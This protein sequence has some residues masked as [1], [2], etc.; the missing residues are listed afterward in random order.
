ML[1]RYPFRCDSVP[2]F[3]AQDT[4]DAFLSEYQREGRILPCQ[5]LAVV[6]SSVSTFSPWCAKDGFDNRQREHDGVTV[7]EFH[8][9]RLRCPFY[10]P[11]RR[12]G[13]RPGAI[14]RGDRVTARR[15]TSWVVVLV[16]LLLVL[17]A[18]GAAWWWRQ[19]LLFNVSMVKELVPR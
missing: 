3:E 15:T 17:A 19:D 11:N 2:K 16:V 9:C 8:G 6:P 13:T 7:H 12:P 14:R 4:A 1:F 10:T 5:Y 18:F